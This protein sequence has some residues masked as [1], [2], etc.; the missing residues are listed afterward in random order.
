MYKKFFVVTFV[1]LMLTSPA[2]SAT[3]GYNRETG[4][5]ILPSEVSLYENN[6]SSQNDMAE[7]QAAEARYKALQDAAEE[8][9]R[10]QLWEKLD[11]EIKLRRYDKLVFDMRKNFDEARTATN[12]FIGEQGYVIYP[13]GEV[14]P[15]IT[16]R[17][18]R[19]TDVALEPGESIM[20]IHAGDTV[21]WLFT[22][23]QSMKNGLSVS[24][25][26]VKPSQPGIS[27]NLLIHTD[28]RT[29]NLDFTATENS[30]YIRGVAFSY[31]MNDLTSIFVKSRQNNPDKKTLEDE[32]QLGTD[33]VNFDTLY[34]RYTIIDKNRALFLMTA[35]KLIFVCLCDLAKLRRFIST[36]IRKKLYQITA[37]KDVITSLTAYLTELISK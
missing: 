13:Y 14:I 18:M 35:I 21:R 12:P 10:I 7:I 11:K 17:P 27:T 37:L 4:E 2:F 32:L 16:C 5:I 9:A 3:P 28:K 25:I 34:T 24:H 36:S 26:V 8:T 22:P 6:S 23:S 19:M 29:Y 30:Q 1:T 15:I 31:Q 20:G 33:S